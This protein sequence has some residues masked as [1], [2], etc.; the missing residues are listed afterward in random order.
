V[1][2]NIKI[3]VIGGTGKSGKFL[4]SE[5]IRQQIP[6]KILLRNPGSFHI[7]S[8]MVNIIQGDV[9]NYASVYALIKGCQAI[10]STLGQ[11]TNESSIFSQATNN[12]IKAM[13]E[14]HCK[15][16]IVT[17]GLSVDTPSDKKNQQA[18][19]AT[20]WMKKNY[21]ETTADKQIEYDTLTRSSVDWTLVRLPLIEL[22]DTTGKIN[23]SLE[24]CPGDKINAASLAQ[25]LIGQLQD[26]TWFMKAPFIAN[27]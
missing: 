9:R 12:I 25:F 7:K 21:P 8:P 2:N 5:L 20:D 15:R 4:V 1:N 11:P 3:A 26:D 27:G 24:D 23:I 13:N 22:T 6:F 18:A 10:I 19:F 14:F 17:T 16:Y